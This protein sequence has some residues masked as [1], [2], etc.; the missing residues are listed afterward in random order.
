[1]DTSRYGYKD[2]PETEAGPAV[3]ERVK[4]QGA[5]A[6]ER[7]KEQGTQAMQQLGERGK[8]MF[9][10]QKHV[11]CEEMHHYS[12]A[13]RRAAE[14]LYDEADERVAAA[15]EALAEQVDRASDYLEAR[16]IDALYRDAEEFARRRPEWVLGGLFLAG[17]VFGRFMKASNKKRVAQTYEGADEPERSPYAD[18]PTQEYGAPQRGPQGGSNLYGDVEP[19]VRTPGGMED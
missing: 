19:Y 3:K 2:T 7:I 17:L 15:A 6:K 16:P 5:H 11:V 14:S 10:E 4:E 18:A 1:M 13:L 8:M 9:D 12:T